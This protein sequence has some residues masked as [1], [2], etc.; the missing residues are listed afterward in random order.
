MKTIKSRFPALFSSIGSLVGS[1]GGACGVACAASGCCGSYALFGLIGLSGSSMKF[2]EK[3]TPLF[4]VLTI[5]SL[6]YAFYIAYKPKEANCCDPEQKNTGPDCCNAPKK[7]NFL[8]SK[9]FLWA[10]TILSAIMWLYPYVPKTNSSNSNCT[11]SSPVSDST[12]NTAPSKVS[13]CPQ[14]TDCSSEC[15]TEDEKTAQQAKRLNDK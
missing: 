11:Q 6:S 4:L 12:L 9:S 7:T 13:C 3:L 14:T 10:I 15:G 8:Q 5:F 1:C 2:F